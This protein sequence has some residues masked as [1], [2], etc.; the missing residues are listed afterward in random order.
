MMSRD[1]MTP[2]LLAVEQGHLEIVRFF[3]QNDEIGTEHLE[4]EELFGGLLHKAIHP[5]LTHVLLMSCP[6]P[7]M[8]KHGERLKRQL[9]MSRFKAASLVGAFQHQD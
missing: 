3:L 9:L 1:G 5:Y 2:I 4:D 6:H 7:S 8:E